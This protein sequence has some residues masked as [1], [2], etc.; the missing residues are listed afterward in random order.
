MMQI[1]NWGKHQHYKG[2]RPPWVKLYRE[3]LD[4]EEFHLLS[5][6]ATKT[7]IL[8]WLLASEDD[9]MQGMLPSKKKIAFRLRMSEK[10][11]ESS[12]SE[13]DHWVVQAASNTLADCK[14]LAP[15]ESESESESEIRDKGRVQRTETDS[16][17]SASPR[18]A[19]FEV[20]WNAYPRKVGKKAAQKAFQNAQDRPRIDDLVEAIHR[21]RDSSQWLKDG[22]QFIP[23]PSTWLNRGGWADEPVKI[24]SAFKRSM[25]SF[26]ERHKEEE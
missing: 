16:F 15:S 2:R 24:E 14:Q 17:A 26:L 4:D 20:F 8:L 21:A 12:L 18:D 7:L 5:P 19:E 13:L 25:N 6:Q 1:K 3:L 9:S 11:L 23:H 22:G 10:L